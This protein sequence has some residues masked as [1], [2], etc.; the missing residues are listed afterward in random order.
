M[1]KYRR[2]CGGDEMTNRS[3]SRCAIGAC[4]AIAVAACSQ[5]DK[6]SA[7]SATDN[8]LI[9][10]QIHAKAA[11][12]DPASVSLVH[13]ACNRGTVKLTGKIASKKERDEIEAAARSVSGVHEVLDRIEVD[14][15]A[16]TGAQIEADLALAAKING[17]LVA[18]TGVNA[19][20]V[21]VDVH[22]G[23]VTLT[24]ELPSAAHREVADQTVR[25]VSGGA[26][27][28]DKITI[29]K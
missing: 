16:P 3:F 5:S 21:H 24:G 25:S 22:R 19:A 28:V 20:K 14:P 6:N 4:L 11:A 26:K 17:A 27:V 23:V 12:I 2:A 10:A 15:N 18:Q 1:E 13:V 8:A 29:A 9:I 7:Q